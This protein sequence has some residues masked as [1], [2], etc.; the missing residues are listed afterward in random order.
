[1]KALI[2]KKY[3]S[4]VYEEVPTPEVAADEVLIRVKAC[5]ICGSDVHGM[6]GSTGRRVPPLIMGHEASGVVAGTGREVKDLSEGR[7]VTFDSTIYCGACEYCRGG[8]INLCDNR[9]VIGVSCDEYRR[10]GAFAE[11]VAVP[12]R[13]VYQI[14][15]SLS[16]EQAATV[17]PLSVAV[18]A[19]QRA[20]TSP[21]KTAVVIG[22]GM[23]G[24][25]AIQ[26]LKARGCGK[27]YA[28]DLDTGRLEPA[29]RLGADECFSPDLDD[30]PAKVMGRTGGRG[31]DVVLEAV[32][33]ASTLETAVACLR[34]GGSLALVG[35]LSPEVVLPLQKVVAGELSLYGSC[36]SSGDYPECLKMLASGVV[37][38]DEL[39][40]AAAPLAEGA[41]WFE[42]LY[43]GE[44]GLIKV[45]LLP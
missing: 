27:I 39:I 43:Q 18:H 37:K 30:I 1:M 6:D 33:L 41:S 34:K 10:D 35:N 29:R 14:P 21:G 32:G 24:L 19:V 5:G 28:V 44:K 36:A 38:V 31:A 11:Y 16:F 4:L 3:N 9:R 45:C 2:L 12:R 42:R 17:E 15:D 22:A 20:G 23:I 13:T 8:R 40:S 25:L 26:V 7:R